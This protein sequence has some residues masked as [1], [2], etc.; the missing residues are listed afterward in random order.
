V[1][2]LIKIRNSRRPAVPAENVAARA[3]VRRASDAASYGQFERIF[4]EG[5]HSPREQ[6]RFCPRSARSERLPA[7][8]EAPD[9]ALS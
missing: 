1:C 3:L 7:P 5:R 8:G 9:A 6:R 2:A 4:R